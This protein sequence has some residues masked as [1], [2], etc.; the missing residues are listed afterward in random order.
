MEHEQLKMLLDQVTKQDL[1]QFAF[2]PILLFLNLHGHKY[3]EKLKSINFK[4]K[5]YPGKTEMLDQLAAFYMDEEIASAYFDQMSAKR[6]EFLY[7]V[8]W[9]RELTYYEIREKFSQIEIYFSNF[10]N[11]Y[12]KTFEI[13]DPDGILLEWEKCFYKA[14]NFFYIKN[15]ENLKHVV[16]RFPK[17]L[18]ILLSF[19]FPKPEDYFL[20]ELEGEQLLQQKQ[21]KIVNF[22]KTIFIELPIVLSYHK[23]GKLQFS[24]KDYPTA[25]SIKKMA[26]SLHIAELDLYE[27]YYLR[28]GMLA[29]AFSDYEEHHIFELDPLEVIE[30][31]IIKRLS[32]TLKLSVLFPFLKGVNRFDE[33]HLLAYNVN[34]FLQLF[35]N[36]HFEKCWYGMENLINFFKYRF[37]DFNEFKNS[38]QELN[39][40]TSYFDIIGPY[41][42]NIKSEEFASDGFVKSC[43]YF[44]ASWGILEVIVDTEK[45]RVHS[46]FD[47]ILA[48]RLTDL[49]A[50]LF[51]KT[52][53]YEPPVQNDNKLIFDPDGPFIKVEGN[54]DL[55]R[56]IMDNVADQIT[57]NRFQFSPGKFLSDV[58]TASEL[59]QKI[60]SFKELIKE[61]LPAYWEHY[62][63][64]LE[65]NSRL[66][67]PK[68]EV[69][70]YQISADQKELI[71]LIAT[72]VVL[73]KIVI[74]AEN[75]VILIERTK[76][77]KFKKRM[78][79]LGYLIS[80]I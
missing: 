59:E 58:N 37:Y 25:A 8:L 46:V 5:K 54:V 3:K 18:R 41:K 31:L 39:V 10:S 32:H 24:I 50:Y 7:F 71:K 22:E 52:N 70:A 67:K 29:G 33:I 35:N 28:A 44:F 66:I 68:V 78:K 45:Y 16:F 30:H 64:Q 12:G 77:R 34:Y 21:N 49:G 17:F 27:T 15:Q 75:F 55:A 79:E 38:Y 9:Q 4:N 23:Q 40:D 53:A 61:K 80:S 74:K 69:V 48:F 63:N 42:G 43:I 51:N 13:R 72:D 2:K 14:Y 56:A 11:D 76:V 36:N 73:R 47:N 57:S 19:H 26:K 1:E 6:K 20:V 60:R 65:K 62:F